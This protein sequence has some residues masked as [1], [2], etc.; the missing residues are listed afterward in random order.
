MVGEWISDPHRVRDVIEN[1]M[2]KS[3]EFAMPDCQPEAKDCQD[4]GL[5]EYFDDRDEGL[6]SLN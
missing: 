3:D 6:P 4:C 5:W 2:K 1:I